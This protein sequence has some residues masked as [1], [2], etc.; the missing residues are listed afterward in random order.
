M[1]SVLSLQLV[2]YFTF[3]LCFSASDL[4]SAGT[5]TPS[6]VILWILYYLIKYPD[7]QARLHCELDDV[8]GKANR[9][10]ELSDK[11]NLPYL[12]AF[13]AE[14]LRIVSETPLAIPHLT[15]RDTF[16]AGFFIPRNMTVFINL[17]AIHHDPDC[18]EGPFCFRPERFLDEQGRL[19]V[20]GVLP[21]SAGTR[22]C[23][24]E[25]FSKR[26]VFLY[27]ARLLYSLKFECPL[28]E[29]LPNEK[30][31]DLGILRNC[32]PFKIRAIARIS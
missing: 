24:G 30:D 15:M 1:L 18:W 3:F 5:E 12:V 14:V 27:A 4:F 8:I 7:V 9:L 32:K 28:G 2:Y 22:S 11:P 31:S 23:P 25:G 26:A 16:L 19:C 10:P 6:T 20:Q 17:W 29:A 13:I 21:F